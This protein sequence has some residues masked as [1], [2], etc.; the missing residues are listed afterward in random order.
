MSS[1]L[2]TLKKHS[3]LADESYNKAKSRFKLQK[4]KFKKDNANNGKTNKE[5]NQP[6]QLSVQSQSRYSFQKLKKVQAKRVA[7][8]ET[9]ATKSLKT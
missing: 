6:Q 2:G 9:R 5:Q 3:T 8:P 1:D 4:A 7:C